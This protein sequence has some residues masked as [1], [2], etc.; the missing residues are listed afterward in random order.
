MSVETWTERTSAGA[1]APRAQPRV[2][3]LRPK[4]GVADTLLQLWRAKWLMFLVFLPILLMASVIG[5]LVGIGMKVSGALREG[6]YVP[7]GPFL[8]GGGIVV[9]LLGLPRVL[10]FI[11]WA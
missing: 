2:A 11:G 10:G 9:M 6:R 1:T 4:L 3:R 7:F 5:A 8:A